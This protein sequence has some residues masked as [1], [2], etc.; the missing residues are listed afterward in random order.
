MPELLRLAGEPAL[1]RAAIDRMGVIVDEALASAEAAGYR[2]DRL[3]GS[4]TEAEAEETVTA[5]PDLMPVE[6]SQDKT[7]KPNAEESKIGATEKG[8]DDP[9]TRA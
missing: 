2:I 9:A 4:A 5:E 7:K 3:L 8:A 1:D 6:A